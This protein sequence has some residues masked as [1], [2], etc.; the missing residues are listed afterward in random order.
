MICLSHGHW[1]C[2]LR[3]IG[4][5]TEEGQYDVTKNPSAR[6]RVGFEWRLQ[7]TK[8][9]R[10]DIIVSPVYKD[11]VRQGVPAPARTGSN[12]E[13]A[14]DLNAMAADAVEKNK[15][16]LR[17]KAKVPDLQVSCRFLGIDGP[18]GIDPFDSAT[19][20]SKAVFEWALGA[21]DCEWR[22]R[23]FPTIKNA[24]A[25]GVPRPTCTVT[26]QRLEGKAREAGEKASVP[27]VVT[28]TCACPACMRAVF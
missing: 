11:A 23:V 14:S 26:H 5:K 17:K 22:E 18:N 10:T 1:L 21:N 12:N 8:V 25:H 3:Y 16:F 6:D 19:I 4:V 27:G 7:G 24:K 13:V 9:Q 28:I 15:K 2:T 20:K